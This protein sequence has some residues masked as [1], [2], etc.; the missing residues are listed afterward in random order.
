MGAENR[1]VIRFGNGGATRLKNFDGKHG[2]SFASGMVGATR[3]LGRV[4]P[5]KL[6]VQENFI[7]S[8][9]TVKAVPS[10]R[11]HRQKTV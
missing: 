4:A 5:L 9:D 1:K 11:E 3:P 2:K 10:G 6:P 8:A 7:G